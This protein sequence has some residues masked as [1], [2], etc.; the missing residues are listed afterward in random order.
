MTTK[1]PMDYY[2]DI[3]PEF[4]RKLF[5]KL[6]SGKP[7]KNSEK[8]KNRMNPT[9]SDFIYKTISSDLFTQYIKGL[10][11]QG[12]KFEAVQQI[13]IVMTDNYNLSGKQIKDFS[14]NFILEDSLKNDIENITEYLASGFAEYKQTLLPVELKNLDIDELENKLDEK[15]YRKFI[16]PIEYMK[17]VNIPMVYKLAKLAIENNINTNDF[18][19][20]LNSFFEKVSAEYKRCT[21]SHSAEEGNV[22]SRI[23][24]ITDAYNTYFKKE[25]EEKEPE[26]VEPKPELKPEPK[27]EVKHSLPQL[28]LYPD[29]DSDWENS[30]R[31]PSNIMNSYTATIAG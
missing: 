11:K 2:R 3:T 14:S 16:K 12:T 26:K 7:L 29:N 1:I 19:Q 28:D 18:V 9:A 21:E 4:R 8:N 15:N 31:V 10:P 13:M 20:F 6:N 22:K 23:A 5:L 17:R 24:I 27:K 30:C 25:I